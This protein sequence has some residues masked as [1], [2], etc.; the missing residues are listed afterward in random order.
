MAAISFSSCCSHGVMG[1]FLGFSSKSFTLNLELVIFI[2]VVA[3][4][5][6]RGGVA[7]VGAGG[8]C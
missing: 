1:L 7:V 3:G 8:A 6:A 5:A 4:A 2:L